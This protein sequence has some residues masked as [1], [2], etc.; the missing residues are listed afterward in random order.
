MRH[1][2]AGAALAALTAIAMT[3][4]AEA[5]MRYS[6]GYGPSW[7]PVHAPDDFVADQLNRAVIAQL[8]QT[9]PAGLDKVALNP[10]PL[11]PRQRR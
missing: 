6:G 3:G 5:R 10:Q 9:G 1:L 7:G 4:S 2:L 11:P 8:A